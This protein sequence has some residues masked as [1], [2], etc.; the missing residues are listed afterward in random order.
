M[1]CP[2]VLNIAAKS[3]DEFPRMAA[4]VKG[5]PGIA[6]LE[7]NLSC[8]NVSYASSNMQSAQKAPDA[9]RD[10]EGIAALFRG[11]ATPQLASLGRRKAANDRCL[12]IQISIAQSRV[13]MISFTRPMNAAE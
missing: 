2:I 9:R 11:G 1:A 12:G 8:P 5:L 3:A 6:A 7:L 10:D 4:R 13:S